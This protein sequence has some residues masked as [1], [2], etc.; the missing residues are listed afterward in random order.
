MHRPWHAVAWW[1]TLFYLVWASLGSWTIADIM[2]SLNFVP[3][4]IRSIRCLRRMRMGCGISCCIPMMIYDDWWTHWLWNWYVGIPIDTSLIEPPK[5]CLKPN[6]YTNVLRMS[7][8]QDNCVPIIFL[9]PKRCE[10]WS[11]SWK[12]MVSTE[13]IWKHVETGQIIK[14]KLR[15]NLL[16]SRLARSTTPRHLSFCCLWPATRH[17]ELRLPP[18]LATPFPNVKTHL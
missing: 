10:I 15:S 5:T 14:K 11:L 6:N 18:I 2:I 1:L 3:Q 17:W 13:H 4:R 7:L 12:K 16:G 8:Q 9:T